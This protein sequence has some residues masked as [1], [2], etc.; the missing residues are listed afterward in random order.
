MEREKEKHPLAASCMP[1]TCAL[2]GNQTRDLVH[3]STHKHSHTDSP[4]V[5]TFAFNHILSEV[6]SLDTII[7]C[8]FIESSLFP[9]LLSWG[10][11]HWNRSQ[12][13]QVA[14]GW[15]GYFGSP[16]ASAEV[17]RGAV[18]RFPMPWVRHFAFESQIPEDHWDKQG[19]V[20][21]SVGFSFLLCK[22]GVR[23][24]PSS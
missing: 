15:A 5:D 3:G 14:S 10:F 19:N 7:S 23:S 8:C 12:E 13:D 6:Q 22:V 20:V 4:T 21:F 17:N 9:G 18:I 24:V 11:L 16:K 1:P 2:T